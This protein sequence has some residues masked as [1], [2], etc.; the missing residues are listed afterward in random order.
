MK[1]NLALWS[2]MMLLAV[3][4]SGDKAAAYYDPGVQRWINRDPLLDEKHNPFGNLLRFEQA[5]LVS[6]NTFA[7]ARNSPLDLVDTDGRVHHPPLPL[8]PELAA[9]VLGE[10]WKAKRD[11]QR[12]GQNWTR[13][14]HCL[15][16]CRIAKRCGKA[17]AY[18]A[19]YGKEV[20]DLFRCALGSE[21]HCHSAFQPEDLR[22]NK[23]GIDCPSEKSCEEQC[24]NLVGMPEPPPGPF[25]R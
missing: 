25:G 17:V 4:T 7:F 11:A 12:T 1:R 23:R 8:G 14:A 24:G 6:G 19:G 5:G 20:W 22:D 9:C 18:G 15:A 16:S 13:Y 2:A 3:L 10:G 21:E